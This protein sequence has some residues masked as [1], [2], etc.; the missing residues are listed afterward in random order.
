VCA[1]VCVSVCVCMCV[2]MYVCV[3][4][5]LCTVRHV[6]VVCVCVCVCVCVPSLIFANNRC[7]S[8]SSAGA[9]AFPVLPPPPLALRGLLTGLRFERRLLVSAECTPHSHVFASTCV[10]TCV[11]IYIYVCV[12]VCVCVCAYAYVCVCVCAG[13]CV[14]QTR[15]A[16]ATDT[17]HSTGRSSA[18][19]R[20]AP[21]AWCRRR[22]L[23]C[24]HTYP[25]C[26]CVC[27][28]VCVWISL[29][30][31]SP[32][33]SPSPPCV[34]VC[35]TDVF[36]RQAVVFRAGTRPLCYSGVRVVLQWCYSAVTVVLQWRNSDVT[37]V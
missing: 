31:S 13:V 1:C 7:V 9:A 16:S 34:Y 11:Y 29:S 21:P 14:P 3:C 18:R 32:P 2:H 30:S 28:C 24:P 8:V 36:Q 10:Y 4:V 15:L 22:W 17:A 19:W 35:L 37:V 23:S 25:L 12:C 20:H 5:R 26:V 27:V 6:S 33:S